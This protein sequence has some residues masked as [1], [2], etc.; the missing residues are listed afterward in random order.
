M[1]GAAQHPVLRTYIQWIINE[2][3]FKVSLLLTFSLKLQIHFKT[4]GYLCESKNAF[5]A[6]IK[7]KQTVQC[8]YENGFCN[9]C[10]TS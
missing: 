2:V 8:C 5:Q 1:K 9:M 4:T 6:E 10:G 7:E 3:I